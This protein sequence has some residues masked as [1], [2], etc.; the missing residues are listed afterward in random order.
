MRLQHK[1]DSPVMEVPGQG[2]FLT[3][4]GVQQQLNALLVE[5]VAA[6]LAKVTQIRQMQALRPLATLPT[7]ELDG[8]VRA[9]MIAINSQE[10]AV[11]ATAMIDAQVRAETVLVE[12]GFPSTPASR[13]L[14]RRIAEEAI[15][16][17]QHRLAGGGR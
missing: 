8:L 17:H 9:A 4:A 16:T 10:P 15:N 11:V 3:G 6:L 13:N 12:E 2:F 1:P 14:A 5:G 7:H